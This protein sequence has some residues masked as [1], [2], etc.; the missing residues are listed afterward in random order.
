M[1][2]EVKIQ[3]TPPN[4]FTKKAI[5]ILNAF[6]IFMLI[7]L[8]KVALLVPLIFK[9]FHPVVAWA[10][11]LAGLGLAVAIPLFL[12]PFCMGN[13]YVLLLVRRL[14][15][16]KENGFIVQLTTVPRL[17]SG[18]WSVM[19][20]ADDIGF[21]KLGAGTV[22]FNGDSTML[23]IPIGKIGNVRKKNVGHR[24]VWMAGS[25]IVI[26]VAEPAGSKFF[27]FLE[28]SSLSV[29]ASRRISKELFECL[30]TQIAPG[31]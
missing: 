7:P 3:I 29:P 13:P 17:K 26:E 16:L 18:F 5:L 11:T 23:S 10:A 6:S 12:W 22:E 31:K 25:R 20:D 15:Y 14:G 21:L 27:E 24:G 4:L 1:S 2:N 19:E 8:L 28:R 30:S 9:F